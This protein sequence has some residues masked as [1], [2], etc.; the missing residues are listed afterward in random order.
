M[1][2]GDLLR[3]RREGAPTCGGCGT[4]L[5]AD[6][7]FCHACG[8]RADDP[9]SQPLHVVDRVTGLFNDRFLKPI[10]EDELARA[11]RY[12]RSLGV[13]LLEPA[14]DGRAL[15]GSEAED[16]LRLMA[17]AVAATLRDVDTPGVL[18]HQPPTILALLPDTDASGTAHA[19]GRVLEAVNAALG[20][21]G[22][23]ALL[24]IV[25]VHHAQR[26]RAGSVIEAASRA[27]RSGRPEMVGH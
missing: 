12:G 24:G 19:A 4:Q 6:A 10:L 20:P 23:Q 7:A 2:I 21:R 3:R 14:G 27:L 25:C 9:D 26:L 22:R 15:L 16:V 1:P 13:L 18:A 8:A 17:G 11:H 5:V